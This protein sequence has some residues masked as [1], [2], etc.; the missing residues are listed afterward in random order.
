MDLNVRV[1]W[2]SIEIRKRNWNVETVLK[3][4]NGDIFS[5]ALGGLEDVLQ[6][7]HEMRCDIVDMFNT[8]T[9]KI[10]LLPVADLKEITVAFDDKKPVLNEQTRQKSHLFKE[11]CTWLFTLENSRLLYNRETFPLWQYL[12]FYRGACAS[13]CSSLHSLSI[14]SPDRVFLNPRLERNTDLTVEIDWKSFG[15]KEMSS[16]RSL[17]TQPISRELIGIAYDCL[18]MMWLHQTSNRILIKNTLSQQHSGISFQ[19]QTAVITIHPSTNANKQWIVERTNADRLNDSEDRQLLVEWDSQHLEESQAEIKEA[20][21]RI[22]SSIGLSIKCQ[23]DEKRVLLNCFPK[24]RREMTHP[25]KLISRGIGIECYDIPGIYERAVFSLLNATATLAPRPQGLPDTEIGTW[26]RGTSTKL[27]HY[28]F[29]KLFQHKIYTDVSPTG[30][31][32][33]SRCWEITNETHEISFVKEP[34]ISSNEEK[35][36]APQNVTGPWTFHPLSEGKKKMSFVSFKNDM[37]QVDN[38]PA[39]I[40]GFDKLSAK[41]SI[42]QEVADMMDKDQYLILERKII[43]LLWQKK[44]RIDQRIVDAKVRATKQLSAILPIEEIEVDHKSFIG[45]SGD[46]TKLLRCT[47]CLV[48][49]IEHMRS[50]DIFCYTTSQRNTALFNILHK[51]RLLHVNMDKTKT[52]IDCDRRIEC[53]KASTVSYILL[54]RNAIRIIFS[55]EPSTSPFVDDFQN[56]LSQFAEL[57]M[58]EYLPIKPRPNR[59]SSISSIPSDKQENDFISVRR[60][61]F[62]DVLDV[63]PKI[64]KI[65]RETCDAVPSVKTISMTKIGNICFSKSTGKKIRMILKG[66]TLVVYIPGQCP[67]TEDFAVQ[68]LSCIG[69]SDNLKE[70]TVPVFNIVSSDIYFPESNRGRIVLGFHNLIHGKNT[71]MIMEQSDF[72]ECFDVQVTARGKEQITLDTTVEH[73]EKTTEQHIVLT[74]SMKDDTKLNETAEIKVFYKGKEIECASVP[75]LPQNV[76]ISKNVSLWSANGSLSVM[77]NGSFNI[78][79]LHSADGVTK[80]D[81]KEPQ[82]RCS[83]ERFHHTIQHVQFTVDARRK[84]LPGTVRNNPIVITYCGLRSNR[85]STDAKQK[86]GPIMAYKIKVLDSIRGVS[87][88]ASCTRC[89]QS[90][91]LATQF[92]LISPGDMLRLNVS[93]DV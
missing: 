37:Y 50:K 62:V 34:Q 54:S 27:P 35:Y 65:L 14:I 12:N 2:N 25:N 22:E 11:R 47:D 64:C 42:G 30:T 36:L 10:A 91:A 80:G 69:V 7:C 49:T 46:P 38:R 55:E 48:E 20:E 85:Q 4:L 89:G 84:V 61:P 21:D 33:I 75:M 79:L 90:L 58:S 15:V 73:V 3:A 78:L 71:R 1:D 60:P 18:G 41:F 51:C 59:K 72:A 23:M 88:A 39:L 24:F 29:A 76:Y 6:E 26:T 86:A 16:V 77:K 63:Y 68:L 66:D 53:S 70:V 74:W 81:R 87:I 5:N 56:A 82:A 43:P 52:S 17:I 32:Q 92:C 93:D 9:L 83:V 28:Q 44:V 45:E 40:V 31:A 19:G 13:V 57:Q 8:D 67:S